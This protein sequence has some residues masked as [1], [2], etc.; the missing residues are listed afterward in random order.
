M[1]NITL[2]GLKEH[3]AKGYPDGCSLAQPQAAAVELAAI[4]AAEKGHLFQKKDLIPW[5]LL[6]DR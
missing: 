4:Q 2:E 3:L 1:E 5:S 6:Q